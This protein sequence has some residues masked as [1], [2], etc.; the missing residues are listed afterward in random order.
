MT[1]TQITDTDTTLQLAYT[2]ALAADERKAGDIVILK[3][4]EVSYLTDYFVIMTGFSKTQVRA[5]SDAIE[6]K[7]DEELGKLPQRT[8]GKGENSWIVQDYGDVIVHIF[9]PVEREFYSLE[10][11]WGHAERLPLPFSL[12]RE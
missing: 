6:A 1:N 9:L 11:F 12:V 2:I 8:V 3:V 10:A 4:S 7:V 5:L